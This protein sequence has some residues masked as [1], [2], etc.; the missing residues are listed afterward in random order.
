[1]AKL[2]STVSIIRCDNYDANEINVVQMFG[3]PAQLFDETG[4]ILNPE[5]M[6]DNLQA[7]LRSN[8]ALQDV[9]RYAM[10]DLIEL[11]KQA[12]KYDWVF[13]PL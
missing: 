8:E 11:A 2:G 4:I 13:F 10:Q 5:S 6:I 3:E 9:D 12:K 1:M 7:S